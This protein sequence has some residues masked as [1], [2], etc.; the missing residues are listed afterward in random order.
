M[1]NF[2]SIKDVPDP[3][4][5][6]LTGLSIKQ[7]PFAQE[8]L[9]KRKTLGLIFF[10]PSLRTR[11]STI[12]AANNL[13]MEVIALNVTG[14]SWQLET[15][16][17]AIMDGGKAEHIKEA[18]AVMGTYC[19]ILAV[20]SFP[21][22]QN[23]T[24]D[25]AEETLTA[26][27]K[28]SGVPIVNLESATVH[29]LQSLADLMTIIEYFPNQK[30]KIVLS[31]APQVKSLPQAVPNSFA[32]WMIAAGM[33]LT[34]AHPPGFELHDQFTSGAKIEHD[35]QKA[36]QNADV[37]Y[38]KNWSSYHDY[39]K[40]G[41]DPAWQMTLDKLKRTNNA[42]LMHCLPVR[43]NVV[44]SDDALDSQHSIVIP[45]AQNRIFAAQ[46]VLQ[47]ILQSL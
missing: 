16:E 7:Q 23:R 10:N 6:A 21:G 38:V 17:G 47:N 31:W 20:R 1:V 3:S 45:Q 41:S 14:D 28:Y 2:L 39:G 12:K 32:E 19:D 42:R 37:V 11:M 44:I 46:V 34:I 26:F 8:T 40:L 33:D 15:Q 43:R 35:Q 25:Y 5:L 27:Q 36:L 24:A 13:G 22:L 30:P 18:S 4:A 29:P 9:G